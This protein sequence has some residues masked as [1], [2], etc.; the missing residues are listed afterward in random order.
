MKRGA[1]SSPTAAWSLRGIALNRRPAWDGY[2]GVGLLAA[3]LASTTIA[4]GQSRAAEVPAQPAARFSCP[5]P[6]LLAQ[7]VPLTGAMAAARR[8]SGYGSRSV[9]RAAHRAGR[10]S[11][12]AA[13]AIRL[14]GVR[15]LFLSAFVQVH[16]A[17]I[18]CV[19]CDLRAYVVHYRS[20]YWRVWTGY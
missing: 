6:A 3:L 19:A 15:V 13:D 9:I 1:R 7:P 5:V 2:R 20:G 11:P 17:G 16:P 14:C 12:N 4:T 18:R 8:A 10:R